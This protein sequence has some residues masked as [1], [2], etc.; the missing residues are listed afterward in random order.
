MLIFLA[1]SILLISSLIMLV[2]RRIKPAFAY[3]WLIASVGALIAWGF[4]LLSRMF[5]PVSIT[6]SGWQPTSLFQI[7]P[8][9]TFDTLNWAFTF[10]ITT[11]L[12]SSNLSKLA[13]NPNSAER[14]REINVINDLIIT[15]V[16]LLAALAGN[17]LALI[18][19]W[20]VLDLMTLFIRL[21][22]NKSE[23]TSVIHIVPYMLNSFSI[24]F[25]IL[26]D[27]I[28]PALEMSS[29]FNTIESSLT[30]LLFIAIGAR[31]AV[32]P[33]SP[34]INHPTR[35]FL[36][37]SIVQ[38]VGPM[39]AT[40][41][42]LIRIGSI[43]A[44][45]ESQPAFLALAAI[46]AVFSAISWL[47]SPDETSGL[48]YWILGISTFA[49][50]SSIRS[51]I[52]ASFAWSLILLQSGALLFLYSARQRWITPIFYLSIA[53]IST[54]PF[55]PAWNAVHFY[56]LP[57]QPLTL[58][59][60]FAQSILF[61]GYLKHG[62]RETYPLNRAERWVWVIY[63]LGLSLLPIS[64]LAVA[65]WNRSE[66]TPNLIES[67]PGIASS[68]IA[69]FLL[70]WKANSNLFKIKWII[71]TVEF[72]SFQWF[73]NFLIGLFKNIQKLFQL[74]NQNLEGS[75]SILWAVVILSL[76]V[77]LFIQVGFGGF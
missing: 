17:F 40:L 34:N 41:I 68:L 63:P 37:T 28:S 52:S 73:Y 76:L 67:W 7:S 10:A 55:T 13:R 75:G 18:L 49:F 57:F 36:D 27:I 61:L 71:K 21:K 14:F 1:P 15:A 77:S 33:L 54:L 20:S 16:S 48:S 19:L 31:L 72:L 64:H 5:T 26:N 46:T 44:P 39:A 11:L 65:W 66:V 53:G 4:S 23:E 69:L 56:T 9:L 3:H 58:I 51:Q 8:I 22:E 59:F 70:L 6:L 29:D 32:I 62:Q 42:P 74:I 50:A 45:P 12:L 47:N 60:L 2:I 25:I 30:P 35:K 24:F 43:G 38:R